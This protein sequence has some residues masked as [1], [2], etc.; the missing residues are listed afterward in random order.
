[1]DHGQLSVIAK[2]QRSVGSGRFE[3]GVASSA[4]AHSPPWNDLRP[5]SV[6]HGDD[7]D[8]QEVKSPHGG[9]L[10]SRVRLWMIVWEEGV[11][12]RYWGGGE[13]Y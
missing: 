3:V 13:R 10:E 5:S 8:G 2:A 11:R 6:E 9:V 12:M 7:D 4:N 1:V